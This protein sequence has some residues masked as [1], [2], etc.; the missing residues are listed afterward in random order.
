M[1]LFAYGV[2]GLADQTNTP[3]TDTRIKKKKTFLMG[4][5]D[6]PGGFNNTAWMGQLSITVSVSKSTPMLAGSLLNTLPT[7]HAAT[8]QPIS[9]K[10][11]SQSA[12]DAAWHLG[13][14][15]QPWRS[16]WAASACSV[17][18][19]SNLQKR[20]PTTH[21]LARHSWPGSHDYAAAEPVSARLRFQPLYPQAAKSGDHIPSCR[22]MR[23]NKV[24]VFGDP[25]AN[26]VGASR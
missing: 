15:P 21:R 14:Q 6:E 7:I 19:K 10:G 17:W 18:L 16:S 26:F 4:L 8:D 22:Y 9:R 5:I 23:C 24:D 1:L 3:R 20:G 2:N 25:S 13:M 12:N 11:S